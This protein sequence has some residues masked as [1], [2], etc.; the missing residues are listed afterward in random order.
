MVS[1][2]VSSTTGFSR[3]A[4]VRGPNHPCPL[5]LRQHRMPAWHGQA[6]GRAAGGS[7]RPS[8]DREQGCVPVLCTLEG[9]RDSQAAAPATNSTGKTFGSLEPC[10]NEGGYAAWRNMGKRRTA[11]SGGY[12]LAGLQARL[13]E[14]RLRHT[15][16]APEGAGRTALARRGF[17]VARAVAGHFS[18]L[19][20][21]LHNPLGN[22][23]TV[24]QQTL[25][26]FVLVRIQV[27]QPNRMPRR[28]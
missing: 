5:F 25:T 6:G 13:P 9:K 20:K 27:P 21:L 28:I 18:N 7:R 17:A 16:Q 15:C 11:A 10:G 2:N 8:L 4:A 14:T 19:L 12:T 24:A 26:L 3:D 22:G 23:V 1:E